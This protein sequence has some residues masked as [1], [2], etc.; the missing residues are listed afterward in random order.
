MCSYNGGMKRNRLLAP[1]LGGLLLGGAIVAADRPAENIAA[2]RHPNLAAAQ[3]FMIQ[4]WDKIDTAQKANE[5][6][7]QGHAKKA[8]TLLEQAAI[9][10]KAAAE[11]ANKHT[12]R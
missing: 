4:A 8:K 3:Q 6:D 11:E 1:V 7:M 2:S 5:W 10:L 9:E 12:R